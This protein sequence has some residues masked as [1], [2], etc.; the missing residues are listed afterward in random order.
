M[1]ETLAAGTRSIAD[2]D[3][4]D[5]AIFE[6]QWVSNDGN[7]DTDI[8]GAT[9]STYTIV[10]GD[11]GRT[12]QGQGLLHRRREATEE[13][14]TSEATGRVG[15]AGI[16]DRTPSVMAAIVAG[17]IRGRRLLR[18]FRN[19]A[20]DMDRLPAASGPASRPGCTCRGEDCRP[21][22]PGISAA[23]TRCAPWT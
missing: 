3:G 22:R 19:E 2:A 16:C 14:L 17:M 23:C 20:Q 9:G 7:A 12:D 11:Q 4:L 10:P 6:Y 21:C 5:A 1:D 15:A 13:L 18:G 8:A